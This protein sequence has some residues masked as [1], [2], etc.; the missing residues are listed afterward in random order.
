MGMCSQ[1]LLFRW[2]AEGCAGGCVAKI[3]PRIATGM[4]ACVLLSL[5]RHSKQGSD[6]CHLTP[7]VSFLHALE[8]SLPHPI[9]RLVSLECSPCRFK[10]EEAQSWFDQPFDEAMI[11][12]DD[13]VAILDLPQFYTFRQNPTRFEVANGFGRGGNLFHVAK[14]GDRVDGF[15][16]QALI[17][18]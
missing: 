1:F 15:D 14:A 11:L 4:E 6:E 17:T 18:E 5:G 13:G 12:F 9:P 16:H 8:V 2:E 3:R 7:D 10:R